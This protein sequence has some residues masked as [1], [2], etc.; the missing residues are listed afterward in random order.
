[1]EIFLHARAQELVGN[2]LMALQIPA[3]TDV[4]FDSDFYCGKNFELL[5]TCLVD[6]AKEVRNRSIIILN[7]I[8][9]LE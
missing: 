3:A 7:C 6:M 9:S 8:L 1:M 5:G 4:I 2:G